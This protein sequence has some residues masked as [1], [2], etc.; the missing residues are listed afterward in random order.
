MLLVQHRGMMAHPS[1]LVRTYFHRF[2]LFF[3]FPP[4]FS[5]SSAN[6]HARRSKNRK[7][8]KKKK[9]KKKRHKVTKIKKQTSPKIRVFF[10]CLLFGWLV[11]FK[12]LNPQVPRS[13]PITWRQ[14]REGECIVL[15]SHICSHAARLLYRINK[16]K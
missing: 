12:T 5:L 16:I 3:L 10:S 1:R 4:L 8:K 7:K 14:E 11:W 13:L 6:V 9:R 2:F 15:V